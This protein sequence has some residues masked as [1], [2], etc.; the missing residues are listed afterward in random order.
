MIYLHKQGFV[1][2]GAVITDFRRR[3]CVRQVARII[4]PA[5]EIDT[6]THLLTFAIIYE[7]ILTEVVL[8]LH[9]IL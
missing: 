9:S 2:V 6:D 1:C 8:L 3:F 5:Q 4:V 7:I